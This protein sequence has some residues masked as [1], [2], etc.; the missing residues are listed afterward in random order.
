MLVNPV[1][2]TEIHKKKCAKKYA[3]EQI[4][5]PTPDPPCTPAEPGAILGSDVKFG[6]LYRKPAQVY[7]HFAYTYT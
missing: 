3:K 7:Q 5:P 4:W 2:H 6:I 1:S